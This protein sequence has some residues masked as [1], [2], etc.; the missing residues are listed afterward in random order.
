MTKFSLPSNH[1]KYDEEYKYYSSKQKKLSWPQNKFDLFESILVPKDIIFFHLIIQEF[2]HPINVTALFRNTCIKISQD[3]IREHTV[4]PSQLD[5]HD[6]G[7]L[8]AEPLHRWAPSQNQQ[9]SAI[10]RVCRIGRFA[11]AWLQLKET[12]S[13]EPQIAM[14]GWVIISNFLL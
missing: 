9:L 6:R 10:T 2:C 14:D 5:R 13:R 12:S 8:A 3:T 11:P 7:T 1:R 4:C